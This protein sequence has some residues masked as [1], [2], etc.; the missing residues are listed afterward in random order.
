M[1]LENM[2]SLF[3]KPMDRRRKWLI[4]TVS[5]I[6]FVA[7]LGAIVYEG[8]K[9]AVEL[10]LD[11]ETKEVRTHANTVQDILGDL[12]ISIRS[13]DYLYPPKSTK[14][15]NNMKVV[16]EPSK[17]VTVSV[18]GKTETIWT[19]ATSI[20][21][22][23][24]D[25]KISL[26]EHD[27]VKPSLKE[28]ISGNMEINIVKAFP[29]KLVDGGKEQEVWSTSTTVADFLKQQEIKLNELDRVEPGLEKS[30][31]KD[32]VV[33]IVR[34]EKVT[35]VVEAPTDYAVVSRKDS[36]L[37]K[38]KEEVIQEGQQGLV[39]KE[40]VVVKEN[41]KE[42][43]RE[44]VSE[45]T[46]RESVDKVVNVGTKVLVAQVSRGEAPSGNGK[47]FYVSSTAYTANCNGCSG[48]TSTG[49][50][51][52]ANP[53]IKVIAVDPS[54]IPLGTK[55]YVEGYGYAVAGDTGSAI[56]GNKIDVFFSTKAE[57]Y[58]WGRKQ[59]KIKVLN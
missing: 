23:L 27:K 42:V 28:D 39:E 47:E 26:G 2:K 41:G 50:N 29:L 11:G 55:V 13:E 58:R 40:Y 9:S 8:T 14:V 31:T 45:K 32:D 59:V 22:L 18:D 3:S 56:K 7:V 16:W 51:L 46:V 53:S 5:I 54:I 1:N 43:S 6:A 19:T 57:A 15:T 52:H 24:K 20:E 17:K 30:I 21:E 10:T 37:T 38:G 44:L 25:E 36:S 35:D 48:V 12:E 34:V 33:N 4:A 49:I